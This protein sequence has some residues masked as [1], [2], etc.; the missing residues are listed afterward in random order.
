MVSECT[1]SAW[2]LRCVRCVA[3]HTHVNALGIQSWLVRPDTHARRSLG[4]IAMESAQIIVLHVLVCS[5]LRSQA[6]HNHNIAMLHVS[7][8]E[9]RGDEV[10]AW[11]THSAHDMRH[12]CVCSMAQVY[13]ELHR[14]PTG[15]L[16]SRVHTVQITLPRTPRWSNC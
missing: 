13:T 12:S 4:E 11:R 3:S 10:S 15:L 9:S 6:Q 1:D 2:S 8:P 7:S 5:L 14:L 16:Q